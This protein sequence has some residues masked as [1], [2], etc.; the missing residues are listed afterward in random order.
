MKK[1]VAWI[2][3]VSV[4]FGIGYCF[5]GCSVLESF[6]GP[7]LSEPIEEA[8]DYTEEE[9]LQ[10]VS[11]LVEKR[12]MQEGSEY[13]SYEVH[14]VYN[15]NDELEYFIVDFEPE[16]YVYVQMSEVVTIVSVGMYVRYRPENEF[17]R[18]YTYA[19]GTECTVPDENGEMVTYEDIMFKQDEN[20]NY[21]GFR[22][23]HF[24]AANIANE[25]RYLLRIYTKSGSFL[26]LVPAVKRGDKYLN[27]V[28][29]EEMEFYPGLKSDDCV[30]SGIHFIPKPEFEL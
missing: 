17:W 23:S 25:K 5:T 13:T 8:S 12:Y 9:H 27:L 30:V 2:M 16:G 21:Y 14:P 22:I 6:L 3:A 24:K 28:S 11:D 26:G 29:W 19:P 10:R 4:L 15:E 7:I 1:A 18:P 20:G